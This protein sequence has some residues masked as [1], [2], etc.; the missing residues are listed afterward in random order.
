MTDQPRDHL[1]DLDDPALTHLVLRGDPRAEYEFVRRHAPRMLATA[2]RILGNE[3]DAQDSVQDAFAMAFAKLDRFEHRSRLSTWLHRITVN[4]ALTRLRAEGRILEDPTDD[5]Q[6]QFDQN[7]VRLQH[8]L[9]FSETAEDLVARKEIRDHVMSKVGELP[10]IYRIVFVLRHI[11]GL[12]TKTVAEHLELSEGAMKVRL[13]RARAALRT[14]LEPL[15]L[16]QK[17]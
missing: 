15:W 1:S 7:G 5:L 6:S 17:L 2:R 4:A 13:H 3:S 10:D 9:K 14:L 11:E 8:P 16:E 12:D